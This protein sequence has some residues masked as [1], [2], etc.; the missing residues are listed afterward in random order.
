MVEQIIDRMECSLQ[1]QTDPPVRVYSPA[2]ATVYRTLARGY[3]TSGATTTFKSQISQVSPT[4]QVQTGLEKP[5]P[6]TQMEDMWLML[7]HP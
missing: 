2:T 6:L 7:S 3:Y 5:V 4:Q 1:A